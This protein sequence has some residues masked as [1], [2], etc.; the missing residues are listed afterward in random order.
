MK[1]LFDGEVYEVLP[2]R[3]GIIFSYCK[4]FN[5]ENVLVAYRM[6]SFDNGRFSNVENDIYLI[7]KFGNNYRA[8]SALCENH[9]KTKSPLLTH[10]QNG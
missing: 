9:I 8:V 4:G 2:L 1:Q 6:L 3:G 7:T 5:E 10:L